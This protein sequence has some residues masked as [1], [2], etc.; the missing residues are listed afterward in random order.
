MK[1]RGR[2]CGGWSDGT[3]FGASVN[4]EVWSPRPGHINSPGK[5]SLANKNDKTSSFS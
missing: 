5:V 1:A 4:V 2:A 3:R